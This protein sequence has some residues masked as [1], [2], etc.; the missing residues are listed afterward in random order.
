MIMKNVSKVIVDVE[1]GN[2]MLFLPIDRLMSGELGG[3][4]DGG[5]GR[6]GSAA[7]GTGTTVTPL[8]RDEAA[9]R[10]RAA[11]RDRGVR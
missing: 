5:A 10:A 3:R 1:G 2:N 8:L 6:T 7:A 4:S 11:L 9:E